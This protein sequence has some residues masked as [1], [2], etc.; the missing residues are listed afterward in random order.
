MPSA[1]SWYYAAVG[2]AQ[3]LRDP[4]ENVPGSLGLAGDQLLGLPAHLLEKLSIG[5]GFLNDYLPGLL[6]ESA[7]LPPR[8]APIVDREKAHNEPE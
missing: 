1:R 8:Q 4:L 5:L 3:D 2:S 6:D 7:D